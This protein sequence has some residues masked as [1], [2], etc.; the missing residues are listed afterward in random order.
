MEQVVLCDDDG[1]PTGTADKFEVHT[2]D[3]PLHLAFSAWLFDASGHLLISRRA[4]GK[5]TWPGVWTNSFCGHPAPGEATE[6]AVVRRAQQELGLPASALADL[7]CVLPDFRYRAVDSS[8]IVEH[9]ICPVYVVRLA[10]GAEAAP[11]PDE[12][13]STKGV[14]PADLITAAEA[15]PAVFS[16]WLVEEL[17]RPELRAVLEGQ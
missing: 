14:N 8:G 4:L 1:R 17:A 12:V 9:E 3:T 15:M 10:G 2:T 7:R 13:D 16:P 5:K 11:N 6:D